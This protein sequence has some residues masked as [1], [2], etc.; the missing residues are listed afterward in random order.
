MN[1]VR[2]VGALLVAAALAACGGD[3]ITGGGDGEAANVSG[4]YRF[5][6]RLS[7]TC[8]GLPVQTLSWDVMG[9]TAGNGDVIA[10]IPGRGWL[11]F[12]LELFRVVGPS[13][14]EG[15][16][17]LGLPTQGY[18]VDGAGIASISKIQGDRSTIEGNIAGEINVGS[19][20]CNAADHSYVLAPR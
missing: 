6:L 15:T 17:V 19:L 1:R 4:N 12:Q 20:P 13:R 8:V 3:S 5:T 18:D 7:R 16:L 10:S 2:I 9:S 11:E 14:Y